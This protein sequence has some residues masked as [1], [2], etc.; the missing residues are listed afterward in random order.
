MRKKCVVIV[1]ILIISL[2]VWVC[3]AEQFDSNIIFMA[4]IYEENKVEV[5][6]SKK[7]S[8]FFELCAADGIYFDG[9][10]PTNKYDGTN[11]IDKL[12]KYSVS[13]NKIDYDLWYRTYVDGRYQI[14]I[15]SACRY[16]NI[17]KTIYYNFV[18][19]INGI[20]KN[21]TATLIDEMFMRSYLADDTIEEGYMDEEYVVFFSDNF[22]FVM[23]KSR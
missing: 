22:R 23:I 10:Q 8:N 1:F 9:T 4:N 15:G 16:D 3:S 7:I 6:V 12:V 13:M 5:Y 17:D 2:P 20:E 21:E 18:S 14:Y 19:T 11:D